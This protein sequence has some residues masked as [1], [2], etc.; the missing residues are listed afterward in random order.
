MRPSRAARGVWFLAAICLLGSPAI[1]SPSRESCQAFE[2][3]GCLYV[4]DSARLPA[5]DGSAPTL[6][7]FIRGL[8]ADDESRVEGEGPLL[9]GARA[10]FMS[11]ALGDAADAAGVAVL[12]TGASD[13]KVSAGHIA[14]AAARSGLGF[15]RIVLA[16][17]SGGY[18][19]LNRTLAADDFPRA[20]VKRVI[21]LDNFY[22]YGNLAPIRGLVAGGG[23]SCSGFYTNQSAPYL[24]VVAPYR[25]VCELEKRHDFGE[26]SHRLVVNACL[27][28]YLSG[29]PGP[30]KGLS[31][32]EP[33]A[34]GSGKTINDLL[35]DS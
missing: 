22:S 8:H 14:A 35:S 24:S 13:M 30:P 1:A 29:A 21:M 11:H 33:R 23:C 20:L 32:R 9:G 17:H 12:V 26:D 28:F 27:P 18:F 6:L 5:A 19:G 7:V 4:P 2:P 25:A 10:A 15:G 34:G 16:A 3:V 31:V